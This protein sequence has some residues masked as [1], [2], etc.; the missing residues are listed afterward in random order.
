MTAPVFEALEK[1]L[2]RAERNRLMR[3]LVIAV[4]TACAGLNAASY[5]EPFG[6]TK[7]DE[8]KKALYAAAEPAVE[9][10]AQTRVFRKL[11]SVLEDCVNDGS[12]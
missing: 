2:V 12:E 11:L 1:A 6:Y 10:A 4:D 9:N 5:D 7:I 3:Q 8:A